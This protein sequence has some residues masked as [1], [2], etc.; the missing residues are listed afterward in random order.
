MR[1]IYRQNWHP[2]RLTHFYTGK[3]FTLNPLS[4]SKARSFSKILIDGNL[5][6]FF[7]RMNISHYKC[8]QVNLANK[9]AKFNCRNQNVIAILESKKLL[10]VLLWCWWKFAS[11][12]LCHCYFCVNSGLVTF[13][14]PMQT[15]VSLRSQNL[16]YLG[17]TG[18]HSETGI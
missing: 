12:T 2:L 9:R 18:S 6:H 16:H 17:L 7:F 10:T 3:S 15:S 1:D 8:K 13:S 11:T 14:F 4:F 5:K